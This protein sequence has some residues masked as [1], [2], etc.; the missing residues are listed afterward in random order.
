MF[1]SQAT[2]G[3]KHKGGHQSRF[4][5]G[6]FGRFQQTYLNDRSGSQDLIKLIYK[7]TNIAVVFFFSGSNTALTMFFFG[8]F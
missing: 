6:D 7:N 5:F 3:K 1:F 2:I 8:F 4:I